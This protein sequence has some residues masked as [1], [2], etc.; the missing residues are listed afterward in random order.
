MIF[1]K[2][3]GLI[4]IVLSLVSD[5]LDN[6]S[7]ELSCFAEACF[8]SILVTFNVLGELEFYSG[9]SSPIETL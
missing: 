9:S 4:R 3:E 7:F 8:S 2:L 6:P 1:D 5:D